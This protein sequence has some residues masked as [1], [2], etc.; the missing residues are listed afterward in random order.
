MADG[1][2]FTECVASDLAEFY[3]AQSEYAYLTSV[4]NQC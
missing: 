1:R 3:R 4:D 2:R